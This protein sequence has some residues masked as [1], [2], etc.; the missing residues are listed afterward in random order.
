M[1]TARLGSGT[2]NSTTYLRGDQSYATPPNTLPPLAMY[3]TANGDIYFR[4]HEAMTLAASPQEAGTGTLAYEKAVNATPTSFSGTSLPISLATGDV[5]KVTCSSI[6]G[7][8][9]LTLARS[10]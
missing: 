6:S 5:L 2:A 1:A 8:K 4:A 3:W 7:F 9:A 10:A